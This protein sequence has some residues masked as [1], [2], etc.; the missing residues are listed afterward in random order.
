SCRAT[1]STGVKDVAGNAMVAP[2]SWNFTTDAAPDTVPPTVIST[3]PAAN[4]T[5]VALNSLISA[6]F[7][8]DMTPSSI[9]NNASFTVD[10]PAASSVS[11]TVAYAVNSRVATFTPDASLPGNT[12]C[13]A[14]VTTD[15]EDLA[16]LAMV[17]DKTWT[18]MTGP[19]PDLTPP[20]VS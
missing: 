5:A 15:V 8:E 10:C 1:V 11:G 7:S 14:T 16:G 2:F 9:V 12:L 17:T 4:A 6:T 3:L 18:F 20:T 13:R 19:N